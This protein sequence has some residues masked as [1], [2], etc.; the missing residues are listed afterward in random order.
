MRIT[1]TTIYIDTQCCMAYV[2]YNNTDTL[3][4]CVLISCTMCS[5]IIYVPFYLIKFTYFLRG[6]P[7]DALQEL[8]SIIALAESI[9]SKRRKELMNWTYLS[10]EEMIWKAIYRQRYWTNQQIPF[11]WFTL[12]NLADQQQVEYLLYVS[13]LSF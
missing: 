2:L 12:P 11:K 10:G 1:C 4:S 13:Q 3:H 7:P 8:T 9:K 6:T 5:L